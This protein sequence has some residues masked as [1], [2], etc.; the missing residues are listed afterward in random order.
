GAG[1]GWRS[2]PVSHENDAQ[3]TAS[4]RRLGMASR[5]WLLV[6]QR[7]PVA[8][9]GELPDRGESGESGEWL[10]AGAAPVAA[11][12]QDR[13]WQNGRS[14][15]GGYGARERRCGEDGAGARRM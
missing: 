9:V 4:R 12:G 15:W 11:D 13:P 2:V 14:D 7:V 8:A 6:S 10:S 1:F 5:L 3:G